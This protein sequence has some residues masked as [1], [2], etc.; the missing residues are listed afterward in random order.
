MTSS[1][2][3][4]PRRIP[5]ADL[6]RTANLARPEF[7]GPDGPDANV[8][9]PNVPGPNVTGLP[10]HQAA[11]GRGSAESVDPSGGPMVVQAEF[12]RQIRGAIEPKAFTNWFAGF[13]VLE[14]DAN[15]VTCGLPT[16]FETARIQRQHLAAVHAAMAAIGLGDRSV[17]LVPLAARVPAPRADAVASGRYDAS[18]F[19]DQPMAIDARRSDSAAPE[20]SSTQSAQNLHGPARAQDAPP[21]T[22]QPAPL[23]DSNHGTG[24]T[25]AADRSLSTTGPSVGKADRVVSPD[26]SRDT[27]GVPERHPA[28]PAA[29]P[30]SF[31]SPD[32][33]APAGNAALAGNTPNERPMHEGGY[34]QSQG[35]APDEHARDSKLNDRYTF[36]EFVVG[37]SNHLAHAAAFAVSQ[38]PGTAFNP[39]FISGGVGLGKTHLLQA[40][41]HAIR[42]STPSAR[43]LYISC[44]DFTNRYIAA[45]RNNRF[46]EFRAY[47]RSA[48]V[49]VIDDVEFLANKEQTQEEFFHTFNALHQDRR[50][51]IISSDRG[52]DEIPTL[53]ER[54]VS[55]F[56]W[57]LCAEV[58]SPSIETRI[59]I[60]KRK[61]ALHG[62]ELADNVAEKIATDASGN[63][64]EL[65]G[66]VTNLVAKARLMQVEI[67][68]D[69]VAEILG[70]RAAAPAPQRIVLA[71]VMSMVTSEFSLTAKDLRGKSRT[72]SISS[73]RQIAMY[74]ARQ[75]TDSSLEEIGR[76]F[77]NRDHTT[78]LYA[79]RRV[80]G[81][82]E[83]DPV[84]RQLI[85]RLSARLSDP[86]RSA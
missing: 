17:R 46:D 50:Q 59:V 57:G 75:Y 58:T 27:N 80:T 78:V 41:C 16:E 68:V 39:L 67:T 13:R 62:L 35:S 15:T 5:T 6:S 8:P 24:S 20:T 77:G 60:A 37:K 42:R 40:T 65:E 55:R 64:R 43:V 11:G 31:Y 23:A 63:I 83:T 54:L 36:E 48:D 12:L 44:E 28:P 3:L 25:N 1:P 56:S 79:V 47:H 21:S 19:R 22:P 53:Q 34:P 66:T 52:P 70:E 26:R 76:F 30:S 72:Q 71:D 4:P 38:G 51:I 45:I 32:P 73:P 33:Y 7:P 85:E 82:I 2:R 10:S 81:R 61:A 29:S 49:L 74:L 18:A 84:F 86:R 9:G 14:V 69:S